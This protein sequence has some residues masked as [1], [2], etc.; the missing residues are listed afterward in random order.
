MTIFGLDY[1]D[2]AALFWATVLGYF[3]AGAMPSDHWDITYRLRAEAHADS[4]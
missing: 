3:L 2:I 4:E 1:N